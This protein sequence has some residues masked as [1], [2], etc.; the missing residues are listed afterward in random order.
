MGAK[1]LRGFIRGVIW[2]GLL[3]TGGLVALSQLA[4]TRPGVPG[5]AEMATGA[6]AP[7]ASSVAPEASVPEAPEVKLPEAVLPVES[8]PAETAGTTAVPALP[9]PEPPRPGPAVPQQPPVVTAEAPPAIAP[10][11][12]SAPAGDAP[13]TPDAGAEPLPEAAQPL[14]PTQPAL[15]DRA[16]TAPSAPAEPPAQPPTDGPVMAGNG[17]AAPAGTA[18]LPPG[19]GGASEGLPGQPVPAMPGAPSTEPAPQTAEL[20]PPPPAVAQDEA[21]LQPSPTPPPAAEGTA[22]PSAP[23]PSA[24]PA[25]TVVTGRLPRIGDPAPPAEAPPDQ[26]RPD[27]GGVQSVDEAYD[28]ALDESLPPVQRYARAFD[29][30]AQKPLFA[31]LLEDRGG[32]VDRT[33]LAALDLPLTIVIDPLSEGAAE[34]AALWRAAGQELVLA[35][36]GFPAGA[37]PADVEQ[38][39]QALAD[40]L[41]EAVAV[42]DPDGKVF[43]SDRLLASQIVAILAQQGRGLVSFDQGLNAAD[44]VA[45]REGLGSV[46]IFRRIDIDTA[47]GPE[48]K[49]YLDRAV[50]R[51]AQ[52]GAVAV[53]GTLSPEIVAGLMEWTVE[54]RA[55]TVALAPVT[56]LMAR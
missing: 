27:Q 52:E 6:D 41:P 28:P 16:A 14:A 20:P 45:R 29:N 31:I 18:P 1:K 50:F 56:A 2:G 7:V 32:E 51:A 26:A 49:R 10:A 13:K 23:V 17:D 25:T 39:L 47:T 48:V 3:A 22:E 43:Q 11:A 5:K 33:A 30:P 21:L 12:S 4:P 37:T 40:R 38:S 36:T 55:A 8:A 24:E 9:Q 53:I 15:G 34:R 42:I 35:L 54:G 44:Q 46:M 19:Q